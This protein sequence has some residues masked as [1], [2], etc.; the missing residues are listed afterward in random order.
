MEIAWNFTP[1]RKK[2]KDLEKLEV[3]V[4]DTVQ[5]FREELGTESNW[6]QICQ[7]WDLSFEEEEESS[8]GRQS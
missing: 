5:N 2:S 6:V 1:G 3:F 8:C 7:I 4:E